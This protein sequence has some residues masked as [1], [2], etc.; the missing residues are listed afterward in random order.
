[1]SSSS[2]GFHKQTFEK[3]TE[4]RRSAVLAAATNMFANRGY[5]ATSINQVARQAGVSIGALYSYFASKEDLFLAV[6]D[7][8]YQVMEQALLEV[9]AAS[10]DVY[11]YTERMLAVCGRFAVNHPELNQLY[12]TVV[13]LAS[14]ELSARLSDQVE[15]I[16][17]QVLTDLVVKGKAEGIVRPDADE[18]AFAFCIDNLFVMYQFSF[19]SDYHWKRLR[20]YLG[21]NQVE[22]P[23]SVEARI[24][25]FVYAALSVPA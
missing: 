13:N 19:A 4:A 24:R 7:S 12:F 16:T 8:A 10:T 21:M 22:D 15:S 5:E 23:S 9:A 17:P 3:T 18:R 1:M 14:P 25:D 6:V 2:T 11:D 20:T